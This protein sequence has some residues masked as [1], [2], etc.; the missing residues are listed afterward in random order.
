MI[1]DQYFMVKF[2]STITYIYIGYGLGAGL[3]PCAQ[4]F[5]Y[6]R[7]EVVS[8]LGYCGFN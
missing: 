4:L 1:Q 8:V 2:I 6:A 5:Y 3:T 7:G